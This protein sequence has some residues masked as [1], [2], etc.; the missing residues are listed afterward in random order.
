M[1]GKD[2]KSGSMMGAAI[3][4]AV[5]GAAAVA[6]LNKDMRRSIKAAIIDSLEKSD[7]KFD[8][9]SEK[10]NELKDKATKETQMR[11]GKVRQKITETAVKL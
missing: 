2:E 6:L 1:N 3:F 7:K 9:L 4:G 11:L 5:A 8:E 10:A